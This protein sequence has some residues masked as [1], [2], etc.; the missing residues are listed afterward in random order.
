MAVDSQSTPPLLLPFDFFA[1]NE[2]RDAFVTAV[3]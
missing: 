1:V 3:R 2:D